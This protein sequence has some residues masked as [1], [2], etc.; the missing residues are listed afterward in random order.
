MRVKWWGAAGLVALV[1]WGAALAPA[2]AQAAMGTVSG[3]V[4]PLKWAP[5]VEVCLVE[6]RPSETCTAPKADG[7]YLLEVPLGRVQIEF[8]PSVRSRL[9]V[10]Y[11]DHQSFLENATKIFLAPTQPEAK[12]I[13]ADLIEGGAIAG[14][15]TAA[16]SGLPLAEVEVCAVSR[17]VSPALRRC[18]ETDASGAYEIGG[19]PAKS[20]LVAFHGHGQSAEYEP[21]YYNGTQSPTQGTPVV[22]NA[23]A[24]R[25]GIDAG[26]EKGAKV[27]GTLTEAGG[28]SL[29]GVAV[30][31][32]VAAAATP[33]RCTYSG[34]GGNYSFE[35]LASGSYEVG[36]SLDSSEVDGFESQYFDGVSSRAQAAV[37]SVLAPSVVGGVDAALSQP[38]AAATVTPPPVVSTPLLAA[39]PL[40]PE[41]AP[42]AKRCKKGLRKVKVKGETHCVKARKEAHRRHRRKHAHHGTRKGKGR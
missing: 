8:V 5:E 6:G 34:E 7:S 19:L 18:E 12:G 40:V 39:V 36:F 4:K 25:A 17:S 20:Y 42:A 32:F 22:V 21:S 1:A 27:G 35:G 33:D 26:L 38:P 3:T 11:Y 16:E 24:T 37:I 9:L 13:N 15:V 30:C 14:T 28:G 10:Q 23:E 31:L 41:P 2:N 29:P